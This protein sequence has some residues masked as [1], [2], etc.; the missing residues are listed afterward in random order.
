MVEPTPNSEPRARLPR[1]GSFLVLTAS[2]L[3]LLACSSSPSDSTAS[4]GSST[5]PPQ[6]STTA[7]APANPTV[8]GPEQLVLSTEPWTFAG[9]TGT[10][11]T[12]PSYR[13]FTTVDWPWMIDSIPAF[14]ESALQRYSTALGELPKPPHAMDTYMM[15][16][17][18]QWVD[19]CRSLL[20]PD[21][22]SF[23]QIQRGG[24]TLAGKAMLYNV[25]PRDTFSLVAHEGWHQ[26]SQ[27]VLR[28]PL[29][30]WMEEGIATYME[31]YRWDRKRTKAEFQAWRNFE[32]F[33]ALRKAA[34]NNRLIP[35]DE[36]LNTTP[37][38]QLGR[39]D[40]RALTYYAQVWALIH[41][42]HEGAEGKYS[43]GLAD[44]LIDAS[45][46]R[47]TQHIADEL[48]GQAARNHMM[49]RRGPQ[50]FQAYCGTDM[51]AAA[52]EYRAF[53]EQVVRP[54]AGQRISEGRSPL[55]K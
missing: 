1:Y 51:T 31:G 24:V 9:R 18:P 49:R 47:L 30:V 39:S 15:A 8:L 3:T 26:Y 25:G 41:F 20:G 16:T 28:D 45:R 37:Q 27:T 40:E 32:R 36:L 17:R 42:M 21:D 12:T 48:G 13:L 38:E 7:A 53:I 52:S 34:G 55:A 33:E 14:L 6:S 44:A 4:K 11:I 5:P 50:L 19:L 29:P 54:G 23:E 43:K 35:L 2:C 46:A 22:R 10:T